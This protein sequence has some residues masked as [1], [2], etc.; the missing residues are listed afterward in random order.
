[1]RPRRPSH[2]YFNVSTDTDPD[3]FKRISLAEFESD[4]LKNEPLI[5][6][7]DHFT[8]LFR[9]PFFKEGDTA[10]KRDGMR[11]FLQE[12]GYRIPA[13]RRSMPP[14]GR[15]EREWRGGREPR[16]MPM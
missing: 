12:H 5:R 8:R 7:C 14:T 3:G 13:G 10:E 16:S 9:Y 6:N 11:A 1:M 2:L 4:A 15:S